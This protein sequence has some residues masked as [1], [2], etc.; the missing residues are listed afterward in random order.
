MWPDDRPLSATLYWLA[1][2]PMTAPVR[3]HDPQLP[4]SEPPLHQAHNFVRSGS[5][6]SGRHPSPEE[7]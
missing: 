5:L 2:V 7:F 4:L 3:T 1:H 6:S